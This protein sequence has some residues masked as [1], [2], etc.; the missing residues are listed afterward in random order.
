MELKKI[1]AFLDR[2]LSVKRLNRLDDSKNGLQVRGRPEVSKIGLCV[3]ACL[4]SF[5]KAKAAGCDMI[6]CHHGLLW[7]EKRKQLDII[8]KKRIAYL[9]KNK[10]SLYAAHLPIDSHLVYGNN[11]V[12]CREL[13]IANKKRFGK[14]HAAVWGFSGNLTTS[15]SQLA[16]SCK[17]LFGRKCTILQFGKHKIRKVAVVSGSA[18]FSVAEAAGKADCLITG[19]TSHSGY[20]TARDLELN[21]IFGGHYATETLGVKAVGKLLEKKF[22]IKCVFVDCPTG[23]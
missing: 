13:G 14:Y 11:A 23:L 18:S 8:L 4:D 20:C 16:A 17:K 2:E 22:G 1:V 6:I 3:D 5:S 12:I 21:V 15:I 10:I 7:K 19:E 9:K